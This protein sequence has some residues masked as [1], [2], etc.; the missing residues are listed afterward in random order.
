MDEDELFSEIV[1]DLADE[2]PSPDPFVSVVLTDGTHLSF[3]DIVTRDLAARLARRGYA[4]LS[5]AKGNYCF[6]F[7]HGVCAIVTRKESE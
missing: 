4:E 6:L 5:D 2:L 3:R 7:T 1:S